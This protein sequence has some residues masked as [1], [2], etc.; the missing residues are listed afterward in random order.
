MAIDLRRARRGQAFMELAMGMLAL[1]LVLAGA[2]G[3]IEYTL[4]SLEIQRSLRAEAGRSA[5][6]SSGS[7]EAYVSA[8]DSDTVLVEPLAAE[9][10]FG[11]EEVEVKEEVHLPVMGGILQ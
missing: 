9:Y 3:F 5:L 6:V 2:F 10:I 8:S 1:A 7:E 11:T 4:C